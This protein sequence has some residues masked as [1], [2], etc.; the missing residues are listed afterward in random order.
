MPARVKINRKSCG[1]FSIPGLLRHNHCSI[2]EEFRTSGTPV[3]Y[4][5]LSLARNSPGI[6]IVNI[7]SNLLTL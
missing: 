6:L 5:K 1:C 4:E 2:S 7:C 3:P